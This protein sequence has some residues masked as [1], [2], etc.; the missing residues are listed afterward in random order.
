MKRRHFL[1]GSA[2]TALLP[3]GARAAEPAPL[4]RFGLIADAQY[5]D[6]DPAGER[7]YRSTPEKMK[8][9]AE[10][11]H[12]AEPGFTLHLGD[13][14]DRG[15][16]SFDVMLPL[17]AGLGHP[18][19]HLL[20]T[21]DYS[22]GDAEKPRVVSTLGMPHDYYTFA[23]KGIRFV[24]LDTNDLSVYR[25][26]GDSP[27]TADA[28]KMLERLKDEKAP[29]AAPWNGGVS[30]TQLSW[31][32]REVT[33]ADAAGERVI[34]CG[35]HP[36]LPAEMHQAWHAEKIAA[37][38]EAH[39]CVL[40]YFNGHNHAGGYLE[41]KGVHYVT[42]R[43]ML[44]QPDVTAFSVVEVHADRI[45]ITGHGREESRVLRV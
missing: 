1:A 27:R 4:L 26:P 10:I 17:L 25:D 7:H 41:R 23:G 30:G 9:A 19:H 5:A 22:V 18:V 31:L 12:A 32:E 39:P 38:L 43:S 14:I 15:F 16:E 2:A 28:R 33:A 6:A 13:F 8:R 42:F 36:L 44:H 37:V 3:C 40:A 34:A 11:L 21:H 35:H 20:G 45:A 29:G 24:M